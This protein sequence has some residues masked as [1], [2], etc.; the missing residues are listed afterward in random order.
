MDFLKPPQRVRAGTVDA[1][2]GTALVE[3]HGLRVINDAKF[4]YFYT[5]HYFSHVIRIGTRIG[6]DIRHFFVLI[7]YL[8]YTI[9]G[10]W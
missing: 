8:V 2:G 6:P 1:P 7:R 3:R 4:P 10:L 5:K 9:S